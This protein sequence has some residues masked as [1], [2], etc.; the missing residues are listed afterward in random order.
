M[1]DNF[2]GPTKDIILGDGWSIEDPSAANP[3][4]RTL[5]AATTW[6]VPAMGIESGT[7]RSADDSSAVPT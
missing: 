6:T 4:R 3:G 5:V 7:A 1:T 2:I